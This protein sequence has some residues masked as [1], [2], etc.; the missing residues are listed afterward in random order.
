ML[1]LDTP[2]LAALMQPA[3][4]ARVLAWLDAQAP[5]SVWITALSVAE[6]EAAVDRVPDVA[7]RGRAAAALAAVLSEDLGSRVLAFDRDAA[8][9]SAVLA[10]GERRGGRELS[11]RDALL[12]GMVLARRGTLAT[13]A[14][15]RFTRLGVR[16]L[17]P[18]QA[19]PAGDSARRSST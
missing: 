14:A 12:A 8:S 7:R 2:V 3:P 9:A 6:L 18:W 4:D 17:D 1:V 19:A 15:E 13:A 10:A 5:A 16:A 11:T